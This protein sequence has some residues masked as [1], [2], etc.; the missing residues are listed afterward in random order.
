MR[1]GPSTTASTSAHPHQAISAS[2]HPL[3]RPKPLP[4]LEPVDTQAVK[5]ELH[6]ALGENGLPYWKAMNGYLLG[7]V[8]KGELEGMVRSWLPKDRCKSAF[9]AKRGCVHARCNGTQ[10][11]RRLSC[12][13]R[14]ME[15][16]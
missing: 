5:Q 13:T 15:E 6:D 2:Y 12:S 7:Q 11:V 14:I 8:G 3:P 9:C 10:R 4:P 16:G 1:N